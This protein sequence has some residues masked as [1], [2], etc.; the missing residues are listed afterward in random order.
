MIRLLSVAVAAAVLLT[1]PA[2]AQETRSFTDDL[3]RTVDIPVEPLRIVALHDLS[4]T[5][6]MIELGVMPIG[7]HGRTT[8]ENTPFIRSS[9]VLTGVDFDNSD[10]QFVGNLPADVEAVAAL[11]PDLILTTPWQTAP[12]EQLQAIAPTVVLDDSVRGAFGTFDVLAEL[13]GTEDRLAVLKTRYEGQIAQIK[14]LIDTDSISVSVIQANEGKLY[15]EHTYGTLGKVLRDAGF[16]FPALVEEIPESQSAEF[17]AERLPEFDADFVFAT[18]RTD[19]LQTPADAVAALEEALP[20]YCEY[21]HACREN[22]LLVI[23]REEASS[24]SF[25]ALGALTYMIISHISGRDFVP[26][27]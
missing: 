23:P 19:T 5:V 15:I 10:I 18:Y 4:I 3:G 20:G 26:M 21:L 7:S 27:P 9:K 25:Y 17:S 1:A 12:V 14:R 13:T 8:A 11:E 24:A 16:T 22:Q 2:F 6:P